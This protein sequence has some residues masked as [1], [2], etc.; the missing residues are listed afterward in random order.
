MSNFLLLMRSGFSMYFWS[1]N[2]ENLKTK[3]F[4]FFSFLAGPR[5]PC[6]LMLD[7]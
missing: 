1:T 7:I 5:L 3:S 4:F 2:S 6:V